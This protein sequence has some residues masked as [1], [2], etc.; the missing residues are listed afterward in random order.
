MPHNKQQW[1][2]DFC[3]ELGFVFGSSSSVL[4]TINSQ[5]ECII[6]GGQSNWLINTLWNENRR[7]KNCFKQN[8][9]NTND[10]F[11]FVHKICTTKISV[12]VLQ[13]T[14]IILNKNS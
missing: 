9:I 4:R 14:L 11:G 10:S 13:Y 12:Q 2:K 5:G 6:A 8:K 3:S 7:E 1:P